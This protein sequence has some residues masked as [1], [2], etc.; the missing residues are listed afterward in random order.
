M[1]KLG[2]V[3][4]KTYDFE[5]Q[6]RQDANLLIDCSPKAA[7]QAISGEPKLLQAAQDAD[8]QVGHLK[9][10]LTKQELSHDHQLDPACHLTS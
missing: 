2:K 4:T 10:F 1:E 5:A 3:Q 8:L 9:R 6:L 7:I